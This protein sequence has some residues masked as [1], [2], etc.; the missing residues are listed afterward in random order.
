MYVRAIDALDWS[1]AGG[2]ASALA[3][4]AYRRFAGHPDPAIDAV[5]RQRAAAFAGDRRARRRARR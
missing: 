4:E 3:E 5:I 1:G 2:R